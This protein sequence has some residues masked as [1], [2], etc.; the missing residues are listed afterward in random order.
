MKSNANFTVSNKTTIKYMVIY[1]RQYQPSTLVDT[2]L[3]GTRSLKDNPR[4]GGPLIV[5]TPE[6][7]ALVQQASILQRERGGRL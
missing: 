5:T 3:L 1:S 2:V 4:Q 7:I 6:Y